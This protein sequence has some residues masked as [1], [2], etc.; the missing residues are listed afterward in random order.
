MEQDAR[1]SQ[2]QRGG[3]AAAE[4]KAR[5]EAE[6]VMKG[7][8]KAPPTKY[9]PAVRVGDEQVLVKAPLRALPVKHAPGVWESASSG[10]R[11]WRET[12][13]ARMFIRKEDAAT[14][15]ILTVPAGPPAKGKEVRLSSIIPSAPPAQPDHV[16][17]TKEVRQA[18]IYILFRESWNWIKWLRHF[19]KKRLSCGPSTSLL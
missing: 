10:P 8:R 9:P 13:P 15:V 6:E 5:D 12:P 14:M 1:L 18:I 2:R 11:A 7:I 17:M 19:K 3:N 16:E 4:K